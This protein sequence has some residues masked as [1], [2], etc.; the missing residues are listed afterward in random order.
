[1]KA[2]ER[3]ELRFSNDVVALQFLNRTDKHLVNMKNNKINKVIKLIVMTIL[4]KVQW[5]RKFK[6]ILNEAMDF[7]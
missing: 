3:Y 7:T 5:M 2:I 1:M 6:C 4:E